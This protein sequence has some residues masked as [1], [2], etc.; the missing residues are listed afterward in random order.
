MSRSIR[1]RTVSTANSGMPWA[2]LVTA[3]PRCRRH[4]G[5][6]RLHQLVHRGRV[7]RVEGQRDP[8]PAGA[9]PRPSP[10]R[11]SGRA[12]TSTID[13]QVPG[14]VDE[15]IQE[16]QQARVGVLG[17]LDQQHHRATLREPLEEQ[18]PPREQLL[19]GQQARRRPREATPEQPAEPQRRHRPAR[20]IGNEALQPLG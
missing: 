8:V 18:P 15:M 7:Q 6:Q 2:W 11:S 12:N 9:E 5:H 3:R 17:V 13:R 20:R 19:P 16:V 4:A 10:G 1:A 14:P